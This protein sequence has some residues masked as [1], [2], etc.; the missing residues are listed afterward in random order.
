MTQLIDKTMDRFAADTLQSL[1]DNKATPC[2]SIYLPTERKGAETQQNSIRLKNLYNKTEEQLKEL[3]HD[4]A[5]IQSILKPV[6]ALIDNSAFWQQQSD[7]LAIFVSPQTNHM[8]RLPM[9][10]EER[11]VVDDLF[12]LKPLLPLLTG[13]GS[14]Y[15]LSLNQ[16]GVELLEG[17]RFGM[18]KVELDEDVPTSLEEALKYDD[19]ESHLQFHTQTGMSQTNTTTTGERAAA[20]HGH[21][22][23]DDTADTENVLRF[24][25]ALDNGVRDKLES[26][27]RPPLILIGISALQGLYRQV[28]RYD[29]L[30]EKGI[31]RDPETLDHASLHDMGWE[32]VKP[33]FQEAQKEASDYY[34]HLH[35]TSDDRANDSIEA[36]VSAAYFQRV[37]TL[38]V[39]D[40]QPIWGHFDAEENRVQVHPSHR[41]GA[42][43]LVNFAAIHTYLNGG[44][45]YMDNQAVKLPDAKAVAA[46]LRY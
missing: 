2:V 39:T 45:I 31:D 16:G 1:L 35:G 9:P 23:A 19:F 25:R 24:F 38:F 36:I 3:N 40:D 7:G 11:V 28:N 17:T 32:I 37:D 5:D 22:G 29:N 43:D 30:L 6:A 14:F 46:T 42:R 15:L 20:F 26:D 18:S 21:G 34:A 27:Q 8:F 13:N 10:F 4:S 12:Y 41:P 33:M 44:K